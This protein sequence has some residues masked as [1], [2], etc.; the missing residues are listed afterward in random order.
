MT[1]CPCE[2]VSKMQQNS[3][4]VLYCIHCIQNVQAH[5]SAMLLGGSCRCS[6]LATGFMNELSKGL[7][8]LNCVEKIF[9]ILSVW[10]GRQH[11]TQTRRL[12]QLQAARMDS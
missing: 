12:Q 1:L 8:L 10:S 4:I 9:F 2:D 5:T 6:L 11:S 7:M 3:W